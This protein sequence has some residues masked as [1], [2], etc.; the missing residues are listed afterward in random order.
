MQPNQ[1]FAALTRAAAVALLTA[2]F[3]LASPAVAQMTPAVPDATTN[4]ATS[5]ATGS[6][7]T[8]QTGD[9]TVLVDP[10]RIYN[11]KTPTDWVGKSVVL[12]NVMVQDTNDDGNFWVGSDDDHRLLIV[13]AEQ[14]NLTALKFNKGDVVTVMGVVQP[15]SRYMAEQTT[16]SKG[17]MED[18]TDTSGVVLLANDISIVSSTKR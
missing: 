14:P 1:R 13:K 4:P 2:G 16:A 15:A 6:A 3:M 11:A 10:G 17:S 8:T 18:A 9:S 12:Q 7:T 5:P